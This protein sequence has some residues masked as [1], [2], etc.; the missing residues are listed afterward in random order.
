M[1]WTFHKEYTDSS[2]NK[3]VMKHAILNLF[4]KRNTT[5]HDQLYNLLRI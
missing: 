1:S 3:T 4:K 2:D 5:T